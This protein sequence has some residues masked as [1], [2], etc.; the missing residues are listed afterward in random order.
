V[1]AVAATDSSDSRASFSST[2]PAVDVAAPGVNINSTVMGGGYEAGWNGTSMAAPHVTGVVALMLWAGVH[3]ADGD[4]DVDPYDVRKLLH[5]NAVDA[6]G[7]GF[8]TH[9]GHGVVD[10]DATVP[11]PS[12]LAPT[13][14]ILSPA[15]QAVFNNG[16]TIALQASASDPDA[17]DTVTVTWSSDVDGALLDGQ[18]QPLTGTSVS[19]A[20]LTGD[21]VHVL[22]A[23]AT[24]Q[25]ARSATASVTVIVGAPNLAPTVTITGPATTTYDGAGDPAAAT[26]SF[27]TSVADEEISTVTYAW[28]SDIDG[29]VSGSGASPTLTLGAGTHTITCTVTDAGG[30]QASDAIVI[31]VRDPNAA[32]SAVVTTNK[33]SYRNRQTVQITVYVSDGTNAVAGAT[34]DLQLE[35][36]NGTLLA[37]T[38]TTGADGNALFTY[39]VD[40]G[41]HG[42]GGDYTLTGTATKDGFTAGSGGATFHVR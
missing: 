41:A 11:A 6:N 20:A 9:L 35:T 18:G 12:N 1:I 38:G 23:T 19:T 34:V 37:A 39:R 10:A 29:T 42:G 16:D 8:D 21:T 40:S 30:L 3:D 24:D 5:D 36:L 31:T 25:G 15:D 17:G 28:S 22:T 27:T 14:V 32:L 7:D 26:V 33:S 2:G 13:V 4:G